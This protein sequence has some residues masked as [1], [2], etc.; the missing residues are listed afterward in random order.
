MTEITCFKSSSDDWY[1]NFKITDDLRYPEN[2]VSVSLMKLNPFNELQKYRVCVWG[3]DDCGME[4]DT[5]L[6][7]S[8]RNIYCHV[9][10]MRDV[11]KAAL[12][13]LGFVRA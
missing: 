4:F 7:F 11:T 2:F 1:G 10:M 3:N 12:T 9:C 13:K 6:E 5:E 8:A